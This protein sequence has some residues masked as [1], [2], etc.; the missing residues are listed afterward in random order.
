MDDDRE[1]LRTALKRAAVALRQAGVGY[2][3]AGGYAGWARGGPEPQHD[4]DVVV[5]EEE[6]VAAAEALRAAGLEIEYP[7]EDWLFKAHTDGATVDVLMH[8]AGRPVDQAMLDRA[9][10]REVLSVKM[11]VSS[12]DDVII[13]KLCAL[14]EQDCDLRKVLPAARAL[15]EQVDWAWVT[16]RTADNDVAAA[17]LFLLRRLGVAPQG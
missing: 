3:L 8:F 2:A 13:G 17:C 10:V 4:V 14:N 15:R 5:R 9:E 1:G 12:A 16:E 6:G 7:P 11:P